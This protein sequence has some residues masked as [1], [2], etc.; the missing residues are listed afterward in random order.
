MT[1]ATTLLQLR[2]RVRDLA[3]QP[4][5][6]GFAVDA[7]LTEYIN[8]ALSELWDLLILSNED[9]VRD[10]DTITLVNGTETYDLPAD[11]YKTLKVFALSGGKRYRL[12]RFHLND[13][14]RLDNTYVSE[15]AGNTH[16]QYRIM[17]GKIWFTPEPGTGSIEHWYV[18][19]CPQFVNDADETDSILQ[20]FRM[21]IGW[22]D[23]IIC[24]AASRLLIRE[25]K[26]EQAGQIA[27]L[28]AAAQQRIVS[29]A[30]QRDVGEAHAVGD[31]Y[32]E[33]YPYG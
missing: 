8:I 26:P 19:Q 28:K 24:S 5:S 9:Y 18:S 22:E 16:L 20:P 1:N 13:L 4:T 29:M 17:G 11:Y 27:Q 21:P 32:A 25:E 3:D 6:G 12:N 33:V 31:V 14:D 30:A 23:F 10:L 7:R 15:R 2:T